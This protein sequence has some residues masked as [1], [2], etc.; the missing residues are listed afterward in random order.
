[1]PSPRSTLTIL[2]L[3][4][5]LLLPVGGAWAQVDV[6]EGEDASW[7]LDGQTARGDHVQFTWS[8]A[9]LDGLTVSGTLWIR[10][11]T[12]QPALAPESIETSGETFRADGRGELRVQ[13]AIPAELEAETEDGDGSLTFRLAS[14]AQ[15]TQPDDDEVHITLDGRTATLSGDGPLEVSGKTV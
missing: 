5:A 13:D 9:G 2:A 15:I 11:L 1:M 14:Q 7:T 10:S 8:E 6:D 12:F 4:L 3:S